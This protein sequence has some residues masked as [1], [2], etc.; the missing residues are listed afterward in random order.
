MTSFPEQAYDGRGE[1]AGFGVRLGGYIID[2]ILYGLLA[3][4]FVVGG[5]FAIVAAFKDCDTIDTDTGTEFSCV[6]DQFKGGL[7][8][9]GIAILAVG[10]ILILLL[11]VSQLGKSGQTWGR[12]MLAI[13]VVDATTGQPIGFGRALGRTLFAHII[14]SALC[15]LGY[16]WMLWDK[17]QQ[18]WHDKVIGTIVVRD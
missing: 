18:T 1:R 6:G 14:S 7:F 5:T 11:Y 3:A 9:A 15:S 13:R 2:S 16:L 17:E 12:K 4:P 8:A 10:A